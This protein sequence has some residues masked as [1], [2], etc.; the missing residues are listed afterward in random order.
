MSPDSSRSPGASL[1][2]E[3]FEA[4]RSVLQRIADDRT[5]MV[6]LDRA[7]R[8]TLQRLCGQVAQPD[9]TARRKLQRALRKR[10]KERARDADE[11]KRHQTQIR[12]LRRQPV[13]VTPPDALMGSPAPETP[14]AEARLNKPRMCY[15]CKADYTEVHPFYDQ[16][17]P[18]CADFN[19]A[20]RSPRGDLSG[21]V[22]LLTGGRVKIGFHAGILLLRNGCELVVTTRFPQDAADRYA[23]EPDADRWIHRLH[24]YG[25]DLRHTPSVETLA[26]HL[27]QTL[28]RLDFVIHNACQTVRRPPPF[29]AHLL[30]GEARPATALPAAQRAVLSGYYDLLQTASP[31]TL[32]PPAPLTQIDPS[33][34]LQRLGAPGAAVDLFPP[35]LL[36]ADLQQVDLR[37]R[38]SWRLRHHEVSTTELLE[39]LLVNAVAPFVLSARLRPI[40]LKTPTRDKHIVNVSAMEGQFHRNK[41]D[42]HPHTNMAKAALNMLTR[43]TAQDLVRDGIHMN[44]VDTGWVTDEDPAHL[45]HKK[46]EMHRFSP[47]LDVVDGAARIVDPIFVGL[48][49]GEHPWGQFFK[50]YRPTHW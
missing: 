32:L 12:K 42:K 46:E 35:G 4:A 36:D 27:S 13:F 17:C 26:G 9:A 48:A 28:P 20:K 7:Q 47:P 50:D 34:A 24:I 39:V 18:P 10:D 21:R 40:M 22:A 25:V 49:T 11:A 41:T 33:A 3:E 6:S 2:D 31:G 16:L 45:A 37:E 15:V 38:N 44:A 30:D 5:V 8:A 43:T 19:F 29:Y 1:T 23:R 14:L